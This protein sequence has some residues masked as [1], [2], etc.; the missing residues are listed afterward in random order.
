[1]RSV[2][3][4]L[5]L[6]VAFTTACPR[7][8]SEDTGPKWRAFIGYAVDPNE[9]TEDWV[10]Y[11]EDIAT[12]CKEAGA[13]VEWADAK[14]TTVTIKDGDTELA[15]IDVSKH[16]SD[17]NVWLLVKPGPEVTPLTYDPSNVETAV[18][19]CNGE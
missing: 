5:L 3:P 17:R 9:V 1:M 4:V 8:S 15:V 11:S 14:D 16:V 19:F 6:V 13:H 2:L 12:G 10:W 7:K 18:A